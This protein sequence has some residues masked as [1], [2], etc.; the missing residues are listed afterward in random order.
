M[1]FL[2]KFIVSQVLLSVNARWAAVGPDVSLND[3]S[4]VICSS[5][6]NCNFSPCYDRVNFISDQLRLP[7]HLYDYWTIQK[8]K[9]ITLSRENK[10]EKLTRYTKKTLREN[11]EKNI[12][13]KHPLLASVAASFTVHYSIWFTL[14]STT[15]CLN[16]LKND[17]QFTNKSGCDCF[18]R[19]SQVPSHMK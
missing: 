6:T 2:L 13:R 15:K 18:F 8:R 17:P 7:D 4:C 5:Q 11:H 16:H 3:E 14:Q 9:T 1:V 12:S 19:A 10:S